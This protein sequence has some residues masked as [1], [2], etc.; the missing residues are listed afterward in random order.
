MMGNVGS[1]QLKVGQKFDWHWGAVHDRSKGEQT[2][3]PTAANKA[4]ANFDGGAQTGRG[5]SSHVRED[6]HLSQKCV[7]KKKYQKV[8]GKSQGP[9][10]RCRGAKF[11]NGV[12][13]VAWRAHPSAANPLH[14]NRDCNHRTQ[15]P[16]CLRAKYKIRH[17]SAASKG[18]ELPTAQKQGEKVV[19]HCQE[20]LRHGEYCPRRA[21]GAKN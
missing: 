1:A 14:R 6:G 19:E 20:F 16:H 13:T 17:M 9:G 2:L 7:A 21:E 15:Q 5:S 18:A 3:A 8:F 10:M 12:G 11:S 4:G